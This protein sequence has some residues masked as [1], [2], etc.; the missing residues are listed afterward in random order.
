M[1]N[2][3]IKLLS[4]LPFFATNNYKRCNLSDL[5]LP[6]P[7][8]FVYNTAHCV[9]LG[10]KKPFFTIFEAFGNEGGGEKPTFHSGHQLSLPRHLIQLKVGQ[11]IFAYHKKRAVLCFIRNSKYFSISK[12]RGEWCRKMCSPLHFPKEVLVY[13]YDEENSQSNFA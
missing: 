7:P 6:P 3:Q 2:V 1:S 9:Q 11:E 13:F 10:T 5:K 8:F 12:G 4:N